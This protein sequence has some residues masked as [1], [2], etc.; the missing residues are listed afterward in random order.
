MYPNP[1]DRASYDNPQDELLQV[2]DVVPESEIRQPKQ[3]NA[4]GDMA[5]PVIKNGMTTGT[6][7]GW[8]NGL[9]SLVRYYSDYE[10]EFTAFETT[11]L[12]Y[13]G[14]GA[15]SE[16]GD[17]VPLSS[18]EE[19]VSSPCSPVVAARPRRPTLPL[20][21]HGMTLSHASRRPCPAASSTRSSPATRFVHPLSTLTFFAHS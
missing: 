3:L 6:T 10:L 12:P 16:G 17:R 8:V 15:F 2:F 20:G 19:A 9:K 1:S 5:M 18:T 4:H 11:I 7:V 14:R 13:G 21:L